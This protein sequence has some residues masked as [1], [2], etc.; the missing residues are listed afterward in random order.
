[1]VGITT[2]G[3]PVIMNTQLKLVFYVEDL[4]TKNI[5]VEKSQMVVECKDTNDQLVF[6]AAGVALGKFL[7]DKLI[8]GEFGIPGSPGG[9]GGG[10]G[11]LRTDE[12]QV[13]FEHS[14]QMCGCGRSHCREIPLTK[15]VTDADVKAA[16]AKLKRGAEFKAATVADHGVGQ[17]HITYPGHIPVTQSFR[18]PDLGPSGKGDK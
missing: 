4:K 15:T 8:L 5:V 16:F 14:D 3:E 9:S 17:M 11:A 13:A 10:G 6:E 1:M 12:A 18:P 7:K 2:K